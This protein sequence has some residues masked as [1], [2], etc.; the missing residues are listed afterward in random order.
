MHGNTSHFNCDLSNLS[1]LYQPVS[2]AVSSNYCVTYLQSLGLQSF[3]SKCKFLTIYKLFTSWSNWS[4]NRKSRYRPLKWVQPS[5]ISRVGH[6]SSLGKLPTF[7]VPWFPSLYPN[8]KIAKFTPLPD[9]G[10][11]KLLQIFGTFAKP[12]GVTTQ[13]IIISAEVGLRLLVLKLLFRIRFQCQVQQCRA[14]FRH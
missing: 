7:P 11:R 4:S 10:G 14:N 8:S 6:I 9:D 12:Y 1:V 2:W 13:D 3:T 5:F